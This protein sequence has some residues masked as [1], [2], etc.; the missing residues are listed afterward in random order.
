[1]PGAA[2]KWDRDGLADAEVAHHA[3]GGPEQ[4][5]QLGG[6]SWNQRARIVI[7]WRAAAQLGGQAR[8]QLDVRKLIERKASR[9][10]DEVDWCAG[11]DERLQ[12]GRAGGAGAVLLERGQRPRAARGQ[13]QLGR[14]AR[15]IERAPGQPLDLGPQAAVAALGGTT[16]ER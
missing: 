7:D 11:R 10:R 6:R 5:G 4:R 9:H 3:V 8:A 2:Q 14:V 15:G 13:D 16:P 12:R 1:V